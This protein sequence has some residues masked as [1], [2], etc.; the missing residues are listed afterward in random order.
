M[1]GDLLGFGRVRKSC[2]PCGIDCVTLLVHVR[3]KNFHNT[4]WLLTLSKQ[5]I[6]GLNHNLKLANLSLL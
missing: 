6:D 2:F 3:A 1:I 5:N 4:D